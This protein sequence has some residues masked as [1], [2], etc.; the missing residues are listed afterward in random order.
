VPHRAGELL[1][2]R[3]DDG[4]VL[5]ENCVLA[6]TFVRRLRGL[7]GRR[8]LLAGDGIVLRPEW[9]VH[10]FYMRFPIDIVFVDVD[11]VVR[12]VV[13][14]LKPWRTSTCLGARDVV[15]LA[16]GECERYG[17]EVG[18]RLAWAARPATE[19]PSPPETLNGRVREEP[20]PPR[21]EPV[22]VLLSTTDDRFLRLT[23]FLLT[24]DQF[25]VEW[26]KRLSK[27]VD[28]V[29]R[30]HSDVVVVDATESLTDAA[31]AVAA[32]EALHPDVRVVVVYDGDPPRWTSGLKVAEKWQAL[33][34]LPDEIRLLAF[35]AK[36][37]S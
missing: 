21:E 28:L 11:Q 14:N 6:D 27:T 19:V 33:E 10:T 18:Q 3:E 37:R 31:R 25:Q 9:S 4:Q 29:T 5:C 34:T 32:L 24:R 2:R 35:D 36:A 22:R 7:L 1:L 17:V 8:E 30:H 13:S 12:K 20:I 16:A 26:T 23:R 15:E